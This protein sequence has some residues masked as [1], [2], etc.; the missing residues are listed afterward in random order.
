MTDPPPCF[1]C[2]AP[3]GEQHHV[4][5]R[6][7]GGTRTVPL[8]SPCH[9]RAHGQS[10]RADI[11]RLTREA[12]AAKREQGVI[13][14]RP[15]AVPEAVV[16]RIAAQRAAGATLKAIAERLNEE[17]VATAQGGR[18]WPMTVKVVLESRTA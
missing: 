11:S 18:W 6:S 17:G 12:L 5:P 1:E 2:G 13:L 16:A 14:G 3:A 8:C 10:G 4:V 7:R 15:R 9:G